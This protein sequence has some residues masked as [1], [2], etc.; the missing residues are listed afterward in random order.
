MCDKESK[1]LPLFKKHGCRISKIIFK[2]NFKKV[3]KKK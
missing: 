1:Y 2:K 3:E